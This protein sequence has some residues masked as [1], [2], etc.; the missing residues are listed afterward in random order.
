MCSGGKEAKIKGVKAFWQHGSRSRSCRGGSDWRSGGTVDS[1]PFSKRYSFP[2]PRSPN[3]IA[4]AQ[5]SHHA[6]CVLEAVR[7]RPL[8][9]SASREIPIDRGRQNLARQSPSCRG[10]SEFSSC[11]AQPPQGD[12]GSRVRTETPTGGEFGFAPVRSI[13]CSASEPGERFSRPR[14]RPGFR[15]KS[16]PDPLLI[17]DIN[18]S[19]GGVAKFRCPESRGQLTL[20]G[21]GREDRF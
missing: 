21:R 12:S 4:H 6:S 15:G 20:S 5:S 8:R 19:R 18:G 3:R 10:R 7:P 9:L 1:C 11:E 14:A 17:K 13:R 16:A 2:N